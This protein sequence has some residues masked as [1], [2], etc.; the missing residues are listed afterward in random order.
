MIVGNNSGEKLIVGI[1]IVR[2]FFLGLFKK[3][4]N[5]GV[6]IVIETIDIRI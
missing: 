6:A 1:N 4:F 5:L 3:V 2:E